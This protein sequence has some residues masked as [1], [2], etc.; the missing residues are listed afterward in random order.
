VPCASKRAGLVLG[1]GI[2]AKRSLRRLNELR[3]P[4]IGGLFHCIAISLDPFDQ[5]TVA[6]LENVE[7]R[8]PHASRKSEYMSNCAGWATM[9]RRFRRV[10]HFAKQQFSA[11]T[12]RNGSQS[13]V[14]DIA[15]YSI[16][17]SAR[18]STAGGMVIPSTFAVLRLITIYRHLSRH[19]RCRAGPK[20]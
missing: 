18:A 5:P 13:Y 6:A 4:L 10:L 2:N 12:C 15:G 11:P 9:T 16:T 14:R 3:P 20:K 7:T 17:S 19:R 8:R 1:S